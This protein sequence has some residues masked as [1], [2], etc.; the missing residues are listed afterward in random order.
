MPETPIDLSI[1]NKKYVDDNYVKKNKSA[2][3][4][5]RV[6]AVN[7]D[8]NEDIL[9]RID[10]SNDAV[11]QSIIRRDVGGSVYVPDKSIGR[12]DYNFPSGQ[13]AVNKNYVDNAIAGA[14]PQ[15]KTLFG[16]QSIVGT[17]NIDLYRHHVKLSK[18]SSTAAA[19]SD[20][21]Y[22]TDIISSQNFPIN[23]LTDL[24]TYLGNEFVKDIY[25]FCT[26]TTIETGAVKKVYYGLSMTDTLILYQ[27]VSNKGELSQ[28]S[29]GEFTITDTVTTI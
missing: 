15:F 1:T 23:S 6:Y 29:I 4:Y 25:G 2:T 24:K 7:A 10:Y 20:Y 5:Q 12:S 8:G 19:T 21:E 18:S 11:S 28:Q 17:G 26:Q 13:E 27:S 22:Y 14:N 3:S 9:I 16:S